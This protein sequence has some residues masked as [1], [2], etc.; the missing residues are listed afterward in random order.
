MHKPPI[1]HDEEARL[2]SLRSLNILDTIPEERFDR[3]TRLAK[4]LFGVPIAL[5]SLVARVWMPR[6]P[7]ATSRSVGT[8]FSRAGRC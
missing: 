5:V 6:R 2:E 4:R 1:L 3:Y 8:P 7:P